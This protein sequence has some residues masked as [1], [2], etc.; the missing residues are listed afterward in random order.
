MVH[1][2]TIWHWKRQNYENNK[3]TSGCQG[4]EGREGWMAGAQRIFWGSKTILY[5]T[6]IMDKYVKHI[7]LIIPH[8]AS[9]IINILHQSG[10]FVT[11]DV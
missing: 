5:Y 10:T 11:V 7:P 1:A 4:L 9:P 8:I 6:M 2:T 3:K